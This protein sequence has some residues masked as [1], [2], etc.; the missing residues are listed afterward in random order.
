MMDR[1]TRVFRRARDR[2]A[3]SL[4]GYWMLA[5]ALGNGAAAVATGAIRA[6]GDIYLQPNGL[7]PLVQIA[8]MATIVLWPIAQ[9]VVLRRYVDISVRRWVCFTISGFV[10]GGVLLV[11]L[12]LVP[13]GMYTATTSPAGVTLNLPLFVKLVIPLVTIVGGT[14]L[15]LAQW[16]ILRRV[17]ARAGWWIAASTVSIALPGALW[18]LLGG[19]AVD[20]NTG[21]I[22]VHS[23]GQLIVDALAGGAV[24]GAVTG[25]ALVWL[26][27]DRFASDS[28]EGLI[29]SPTFTASSDGARDPGTN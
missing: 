27:R 28:S 25:L 16:L 19:S 17:V 9:G 6:L 5:N 1:L 24:S 26:L 2:D 7:S 4:W 18:L 14:V 15:G 3:A 20:P 10:A 13:I 8:S 12:V 21:L 29:G 22:E 23:P 11:P